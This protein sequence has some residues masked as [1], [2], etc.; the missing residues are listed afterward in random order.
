[1]SI[2][3]QVEDAAFLG[4]H[5]RH[6][7][8]LTNLM[9][10]VAASSRK[11]FPRGT[12]SI[13]KPNE[14]M[15]DREAFTQFLGG[16]IRRLL[17]GSY[18]SPEFGDSGL[19]IGFKGKQ[20]DIAYILY[21]LYRCELVHE[22]E[23]PEDV[24]FSAGEKENGLAV[25]QHGLSVSIS[26]GEKLV[27]E[28]GWIGLLSQ[29]VANARCNGSEFGI[30]HFELIPRGTATEAEIEANAIA[31]YNMTPG[32]F[33]I[34]REVVRLISPTTVEASDDTKL[35]LNFLSLLQA[36]QISGGAVTGLASRDLSTY[37]GTLLP[38]G[39]SAVREIAASYA[40]APA[41]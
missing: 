25:S 26:A 24:E 36:G 38:K 10:A 15:S 13:E 23:L 29:A 7:G 17:F 32:R 11:A 12:K 4:Q 31:K 9:L 41:S 20:Y 27:L 2:R 35:N 8:A 33:Q 16:R 34:L 28:H 6:L 19:S 39:L 14:P 37:E 3:Q 1:M 21:K 30:V 40:L 18:G 5:G 22:G